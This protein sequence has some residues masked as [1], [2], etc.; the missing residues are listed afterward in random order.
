[1]MHIDEFASQL[2]EDISAC[3]ERKSS[4][5]E[6]AR[7]VGNVQ[8]SLAANNISKEGR[9]RFWEQV[10]HGIVYAGELQEAQ[11]ANQF[12][13]LVQQVTDLLNKAQIDAA[14]R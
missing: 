10:K 8:C 6:V 3:I 14:R 2:A 9:V 13:R 4:L 1:M 11:G 7:L 12:V 5:D